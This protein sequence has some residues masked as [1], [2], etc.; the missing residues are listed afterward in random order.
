MRRM[1]RVKRKTTVRRRR[2]TSTLIKRSK[3]EVK[4]YTLTKTGHPTTIHNDVGA[5]STLYG[6][7]H[8]IS[9]LFGGII[10]GT[11]N[12]TR[13]GN[14][15]YVKFIQ[16]YITTWSCP[17]DEEYP[18]GTYLF[19]TIVSDTGI[20]ADVTAGNPVLKYFAPNMIRNINSLINRTKIGVKYDKFYTV[21]ASGFPNSGIS[22]A[23]NLGAI[24]RIS[25]AV[26]IGKVIEYQNGTAQVKNEKDDLHFMLLAAV[27]GMSSTLDGKQ[28]C[29]SDIIMRIYYTDV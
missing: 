27:P 9:N 7:Q 1:K 8:V 28:I 26:P 18:M 22:P 19:R 23:T 17:D 11:T 20:G 16:F 29:C 4:Y 25:F 14:R 5:S 12:D 10:Q 15:I 13:V 24:K 2:R 3:P 21:T 6:N